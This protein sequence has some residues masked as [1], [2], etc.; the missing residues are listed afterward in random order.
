MSDHV[1]VL[2]EVHSQLGIHRLIKAVKGRSSRLVRDEFPWP[3]S[4]L[5]TLWTNSYFLSTV[6]G[7]PLA[8]VKQY[9]ENQKRV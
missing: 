2:V 7:A 1:H 3:E 9:T 8:V 6:G 4:R 5:A